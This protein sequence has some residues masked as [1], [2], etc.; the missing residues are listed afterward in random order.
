[1]VVYPYYLQGFYIKS[2]WV[3]WDFFHQQY[4]FEAHGADPRWRVEHPWM[5]MCC[6]WKDSPASWWTKNGLVRFKSC[7]EVQMGK[8]RNAWYINIYNI[9]TYCKY[10]HTSRIN[11]EVFFVRGWGKDGRTKILCIFVPWCIV[12]RSG[13]DTVMGLW[14][15]VLTR[16]EE[17]WKL[18]VNMLP[19][20][21]FHLFSPS[22]LAINIL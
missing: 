19:L 22:F 18:T 14:S 9:H 8:I 17:F 12:Q 6:S 16:N 20:C 4:I 2:R 15:I 11:K 1:M 3:V 7:W 5:R 13:P 21:L 10:I